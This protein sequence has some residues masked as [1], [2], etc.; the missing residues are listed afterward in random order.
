MSIVTCAPKLGLSYYT[1]RK[2]ENV[3][4][5]IPHLMFSYDLNAYPYQKMNTVE[6][7]ESLLEWKDPV[8][9]ECLHVLRVAC[10]KNCSTISIVLK[11]VLACNVFGEYPD[12]IKF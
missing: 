3:L 2:S 4:F 8:V 10:F 5:P 1:I 9:F 12:P 6:D 11:L 7:A